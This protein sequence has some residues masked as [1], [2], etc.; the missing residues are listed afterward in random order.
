[1]YFSILG[2]QNAGYAV[3]FGMHIEQIEKLIFRRLHQS[4]LRMEYISL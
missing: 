3:F 1:M 4:S 2:D